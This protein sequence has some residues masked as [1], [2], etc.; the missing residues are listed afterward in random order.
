MEETGSGTLFQRAQGWEG[1]QFFWRPRSCLKSPPE[2]SCSLKNNRP[3]CEIQ[4]SCSGRREGKKNSNSWLWNFLETKMPALRSCSPLVTLPHGVWR[5]LPSLHHRVSAR[6]HAA[7]QQMQ[8][9]GPPR[10]GHGHAPATRTLSRLPALDNLQWSPGFL[11]SL[12]YPLSLRLSI[13]R[14]LSEES[15]SC[16][17]CAGRG[18]Y[19]AAFGLQDRWWTISL[20]GR[21]VRPQILQGT[22]WLRALVQAAS[23]K[24]SRS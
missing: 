12:L 9:D 19:L 17:T 7:A 6:K 24:A 10:H 18:L 23:F 14:S 3:Y 5:A 1:I 8:S 13:P 22:N 4:K 21:K 11:V 2:P 15:K 16:N 20:S